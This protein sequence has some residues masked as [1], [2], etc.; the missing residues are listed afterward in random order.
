[1]SP[2]L[3]RSRREICPW[4]KALTISK[5]FFWAFSAS[6]IRAFEAFNGRYMT[7]PFAVESVSWF[8]RP[9]LRCSRSVEAAC[10]PPAHGR[11]ALFDDEFTIC[12]G[13]GIG[14][15]SGCVFMSDPT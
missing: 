9:R 14:V 5:R 6:L 12:D 11:A 13:R 10:L 8:L 2:I 4:D 15:R 1:M 7:V 3:K